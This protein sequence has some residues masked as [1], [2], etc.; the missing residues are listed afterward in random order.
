M[1]TTAGTFNLYEL[2]TTAQGVKAAATWLL[3][4]R[5]L[6]QFSLDAEIEQHEG[7]LI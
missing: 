7:S 1:T 4:R 3:Q 2:L 6:A 5:I